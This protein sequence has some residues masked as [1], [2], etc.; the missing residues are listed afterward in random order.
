MSHPTFN[1]TRGGRS[2]RLL[3]R[4]RSIYHALNDT[5]NPLPSQELSRM[6]N[7]PE[8]TP[9]SIPIVSDWVCA[10]CLEGTDHNPNVVEHECGRHSYHISCMYD[11]RNSDMRCA[12]C[13]QP[14]VI[15]TTQ[16]SGY[17]TTEVP[18]TPP[19]SPILFDSIPTITLGSTTSRPSFIQSTHSAMPRF[20]RTL[21]IYPTICSHCR[22]DIAP[23][24]MHV[25]LI[26]CN[27]HIHD[28]CIINV[29]LSHGFTSMGR[30][31]CILCEQ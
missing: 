20:R 23:Q 22:R 25:T 12:Q 6:H 21:S 7:A 2:S 10:I 28:S 8:S 3:T 13:R 17:Q 26:P 30:V 14:D 18:S 1:M 16:D 19:S 9:N 5:V 4:S 15:E 27:H 29:M 31:T 24:L 11:S